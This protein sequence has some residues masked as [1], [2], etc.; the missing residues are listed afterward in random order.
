[1]LASEGV[2]GEA[3]CA[4]GEDGGVEGYDALEDEGVG[5]ALERG[6]RSEM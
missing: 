4:F 3:R 1:M 6:G 5:F 2:E